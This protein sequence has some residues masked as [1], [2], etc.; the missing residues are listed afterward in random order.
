MISRRGLLQLMAASAA[1]PISFGDSSAQ[2]RPLAGLFPIAFSPFTPDN[3]LDLEALANQVKFCNRG[4]V[5]GLI[6]PQLASAWSTLS[7]SE[8]MEGTEALITAGKGGRTAM[9]VGVQSPD[10]AAI[11]RYSKLATRLGA[12]AIISLPPSGV[13]DEKTLLDYYQTVGRTTELPMFAQFVGNMSVDLLVEM[14]RTIPNLRYVKDEAGEPLARV[15]QIRERTGGRVK[16]FS[17]K[18]VQTMI[19]EMELGFSGHCPYTNLADLYASAYDLFHAGKK[20]EA[21]DMFGRV[22]A[23][24]SIMPVNTIDIMIARGV[25]KEGTRTRTGPPV[26]GAPS[27]PHPGPV[28]TGDQIREKLQTYLGPWLRA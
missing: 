25:F 17:G 11:T 27:K 5:H 22:L 21:Y 24:G 14:F 2:A 16:V 10:P 3:K 28:L 8:R 6:W 4:G 7:D 19:T 13:T 9:V 18:G 26:P 12:D 23:M 20:R 1:P 15:G